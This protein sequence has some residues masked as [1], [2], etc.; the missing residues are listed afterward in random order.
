MCCLY[1]GSDMMNSSYTN[2]SKEGKTIKWVYF[3][4]Q[5]P[6]MRMASFLFNMKS[7][8]IFF[9]NFAHFSHDLVSFV[10]SNSNS[11]LLHAAESVWCEK[12]VKTVCKNTLLQ[13]KNASTTLQHKD[14]V[15]ISLII[16]LFHAFC[17]A[18]SLFSFPHANK[19]HS[20]ISRR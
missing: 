4:V 11:P 16:S 13:R 2:W 15:I 19:T 14:Y 9:C 17:V 1:W 8:S 7:M 12:W 10:Y 18:A 20:K 3:L 6:L 5:L